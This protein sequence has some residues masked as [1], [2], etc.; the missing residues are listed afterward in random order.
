MAAIE[1]GVTTVDDARRAAAGGASSVEVSVDLAADGLTPPLELVREVREAVSIGVNVIVRPHNAGFVYTAAEQEVML[2]DAA[3]LRA[4]GVDGLVAGAHRP[5]GTFDT[6][7]MRALKAAAP[8]LTLTL[9]R[10]LDTCSDPENTLAVLSGVAGRVLASGRATT[11]WDGRETLRAWVGRFGAAYR[12]AA[13]GRVRHARAVELVRYTGAHELHVASAVMR[14]GVVDSE[15]V[16]ALV[17]V[18]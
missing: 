12:F 13:A 7:L 15:L 9:H 1:I 6:D 8:G 5:D 14:D 16:R 10:A 18:V 17:E 11:A 4:L 3:A 2:R